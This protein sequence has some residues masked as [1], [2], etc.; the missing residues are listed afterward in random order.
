M[1]SQGTRWILGEGALRQKGSGRIKR[2][3]LKG[4]CPMWYGPQGGSGKQALKM[5]TF[6]EE[7][8]D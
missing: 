5:K 3:I 1:Q 8:V 7:G 2:R 6:I 4:E